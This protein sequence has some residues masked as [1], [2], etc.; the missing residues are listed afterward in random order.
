V[1]DSSAILPFTMPIFRIQVGSLTFATRS[2][3]TIDR[4]NKFVEAVAVCEQAGT[5]GNIDSGTIDTDL[6]SGTLLDGMS[7]PLGLR[8][9]NPTA[10]LN[11]QN[12]ESLEARHTRF[13]QYIQSLN[14]S[15]LVGIKSTV[16]SIPGVILCYVNDNINPVT[17]LNEN[18]WINVFISDGSENP[19]QTLKDYI[20]KVLK[21]DVNNPE[22]FPGIVSAGSEVSVGDIKIIKANFEISVEVLSTTKMDASNIA[23][24]V[25]NA[26]NRYVNSLLNGQDV[27]IDTLR[28]VI[29]LSHPEFYKVTIHTPTENI[30]VGQD[31]LARFGGQYGG[32]MTIREIKKVQHE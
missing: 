16:S 15:T 4:N 26:T 17:G 22:E 30:K 13:Q 7:L 25:M 20:L 10:F 31:S 21:G 3:V 12:L 19:S 11:G 1:V 9:Y 2:S 32:K 14:K 28:S 24:F 8:I 6:G 23:S 29:L 5:D 27:I 18:G